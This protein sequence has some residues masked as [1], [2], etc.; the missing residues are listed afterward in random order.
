MKRRS[1][2][3]GMVFSVPLPSERFA[4]GVVTRHSKSAVTVGYFFGPSREARPE[5]HDELTPDQAI[6]VARFG[7]IPLVSGEWE[8]LG[9]LPGWDR[10]KWPSTA[11]LRGDIR[12]RGYVVHYDDHDPNEV[13]GELP[14][15]P[16]EADSLPSDDLCGYLIVRNRLSKLLSDF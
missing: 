7:D 6:L 8:V 2:R 1:I 4:L 13:I 16:G 15:G 10:S 12:G 3:E 14:S 11:F 9:I 5:L